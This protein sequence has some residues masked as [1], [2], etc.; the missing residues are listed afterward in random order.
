MV[1]SVHS[2]QLVH[3]ATS[4]IM[5]HLD[6]EHSKFPFG[7]S[8]VPPRLRGGWRESAGWGHTGT[9]VPWRKTRPLPSPKTGREQKLLRRHQARGI[10]RAPDLAMLV[11]LG[12]DGR[13]VLG[14]AIP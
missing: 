9:A 5:F 13:H 12:K 14:A 1:A 4:M 6:M 7:R 2:W 10:E 8:L 11:H 3:S